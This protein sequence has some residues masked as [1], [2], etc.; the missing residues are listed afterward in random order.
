MGPEN[1]SDLSRETQFVTVHSLT[2]EPQSSVLAQE[3]QKVNI[4]QIP[5]ATTGG[6]SGAV[7][8]EPAVIPG[9]CACP[10]ESMLT[11]PI[12]DC[13]LV[14]AALLMYARAL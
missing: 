4:P 14:A 12:C 7:Y 3:P 6:G 13:L 10:L 5:P 1:F 2:A 8:S 9:V 11:G